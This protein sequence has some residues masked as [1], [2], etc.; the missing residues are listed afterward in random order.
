M[1][2]LGRSDQGVI[3][4]GIEIRDNLNALENNLKEMN[5]ILRRQ[6]KNPKVI[7]FQNF[8]LNFSIINFFL[9]IFKR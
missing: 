6:A 1:K 7:S 2:K 5:N 9:E 8:I 4:M 3:S